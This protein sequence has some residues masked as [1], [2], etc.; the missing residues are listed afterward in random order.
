VFGGLRGIEERVQDIILFKDKLAL[1]NIFMQEQIFLI[2]SLSKQH[3]SRILEIIPLR[4]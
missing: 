4:E 2:I 3:F 1:P